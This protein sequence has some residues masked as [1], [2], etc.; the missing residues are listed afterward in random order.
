MLTT[1][2]TIPK[3]KKKINK[4]NFVNHDKDIAKNIHSHN[5]S[6]Y[7]ME[8]ADWIRQIAAARQHLQRGQGC[9]KKGTVRDTIKCNRNNKLLISSHYRALISEANAD[10]LLELVECCFNILNGKVPLNAKDRQYLAKYAR[11]AR[12]L[13]RVRTANSARRALL[14]QKPQHGRGFPVAALASIIASTVMPLL[15]NAYINK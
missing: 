10:Q 12:A 9:L 13:S 2:S 8:N 3:K 1:K 11:H 5:I 6:D 15:T 4:I 14:Q 7:V